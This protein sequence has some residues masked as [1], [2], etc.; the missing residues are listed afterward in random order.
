MYGA[1]EVAMFRSAQV[2]RIA[3]RIIDSQRH[4]VNDVRAIPGDG[5]VTLVWDDLAEYSR[6]PIYGRDFEDI[7]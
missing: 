1:N 4:H 2:A 3:V 6:D 7:G 5:K